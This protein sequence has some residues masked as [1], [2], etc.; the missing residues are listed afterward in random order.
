MSV[1]MRKDGLWFVQWRHPDPPPKLKRKYFGKGPEAEAAARQYNTD[2]GLRSYQPRTPTAFSHTFAELAEAYLADRAGHMQP[3]SLENLWTKLRGVILPELGRLET[4]RITHAR[5]DAYVKKRLASVKRTTAHREVTDI[6]AITAWAA[7]K[8][9]LVA[10]PL[11]G[12]RKPKRDDAIIQP[13]TREESRR[14]IAHSPPHVA[15]AL[16]IVYYTGIR[17]GRAE[18]LA[19]PWAAVDFAE[20]VLFVVSAKKNGPI[21]R[22]IPITDAFMAHL[23]AWRTEDD[24]LDRELQNNRAHP[25][26]TIIHFKGKP[27]RSIKTAFNAA[28]RRAGITRRL[29]PYSFRHAFATT[30][31]NHG[32]DLKST[33][34]MLGHSR[35]DTTLRVYQHTALAVQRSAVDRLPDL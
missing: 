27:V 28:K 1:H 29:T 30:L 23:K 13:P 14:I 10:D 19:L 4:A 5:M 20:R 31:L 11:A 24:A 2:L 25:V 8:K 26:E 17:P 35:E 7:R 9:Y 12:Y 16:R 18:L 3:T 34:A 15:R 32:A 21:K 22:L 6:M 33:S